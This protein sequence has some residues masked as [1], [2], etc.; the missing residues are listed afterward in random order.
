LA[1]VA[2]LDILQQLIKPRCRLEHEGHA[3]MNIGPVG[4]GVSVIKA[5][6]HGFTHGVESCSVMR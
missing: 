2:T 5:Q 4:K 3:L 1:V 6:G